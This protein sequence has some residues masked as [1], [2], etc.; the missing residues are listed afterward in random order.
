VND[1]R[2][3]TPLGECVAQTSFGDTFTRPVSD[4]N[5]AN[6][7]QFKTTYID[8]ITNPAAESVQMLWHCHKLTRDNVDER[9]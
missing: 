6:I 3:G 2:A 8:R 4:L 9:I 5:G 7:P 1:A